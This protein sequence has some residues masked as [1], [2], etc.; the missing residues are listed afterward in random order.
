MGSNWGDGRYSVRVR[1]LFIHAVSS[2]HHFLVVSMSRI[3]LNNVNLHYPVV[4]DHYRSLRRAALR[5]VTRGKMYGEDSDVSVVHV[6]RA[7]PRPRS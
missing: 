4:Q 1:V 2:P 3:I 6:S 5:S 7:R